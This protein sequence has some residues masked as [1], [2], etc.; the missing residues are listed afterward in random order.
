MKFFGF[1]NRLDIYVLKIFFLDFQ[2]LLVKRGLINQMNLFKWYFYFKISVEE[3]FE[4]LCNQLFFGLLGRKLFRRFLMMFFK[5][6][7]KSVIRDV[8]YIF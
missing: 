6:R 3:V 5:K 7:V 1:L 2:I 8:F 4:L